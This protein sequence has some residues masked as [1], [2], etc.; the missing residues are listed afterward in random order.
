VEWV[1]LCI[2]NTIL[3]CGMSGTCLAA[4]IGEGTPSQSLDGI[5]KKEKVLSMLALVCECTYNGVHV[6]SVIEFLFLNFSFFLF[7]FFFS[8]FF[9]LK[10]IACL[11][12]W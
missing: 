8:L 12:L 6:K 11:I 1:R 7:L 4:V 3:V 10:Y 2:T 5:E 9:H